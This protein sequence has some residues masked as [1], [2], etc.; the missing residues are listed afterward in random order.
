[1]TSRI[2][3][4]P[5][6]H[7]GGSA[8]PESPLRHNG[9]GP[10]SNGQPAGG[11]DGSGT[12]QKAA[13]LRLRAEI[14]RIITGHHHD[15][16]A[17]LGGHA[18]DEGVVIRALRPLAKSVTAVLPDGT[19]YPM[20]HLHQGVFQATLPPG[21][22]AV[23]DYRL[24]VTW[25][26]TPLGLQDDPYRHLPTVGE[27]DLHLIGEGRHEQLWQVLGA[28]VRRFGEAGEAG[29]FS[30][31]VTGTSFAVWAPSAQGVRV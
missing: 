21:I 12:R 29:P 28:R 6:T 17:V 1:M 7:G 25:D 11:P 15:P 14:D 5:S 30:K 2:P 22:A 18:T 19:R 26:D 24:E 23:P 13:D 4:P 10:T 31:E 20:P 27:I 9:T 3:E 16:H 8:P